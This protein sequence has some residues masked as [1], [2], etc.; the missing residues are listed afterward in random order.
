MLELQLHHSLRQ[1]HMN[2]HQQLHLHYS[3]LQLA[4][5]IQEL[6]QQALH[7]VFHR[8]KHMHQLQTRR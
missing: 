7:K 2:H 5:Y 6:L 3:Y 4:L 1:I 8:K